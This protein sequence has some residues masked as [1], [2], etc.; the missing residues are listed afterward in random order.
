MLRSELI[1]S[2]WKSW[3][4]VQLRIPNRDG[5]IRLEELVFWPTLDTQPRCCTPVGRVCVLSYFGFPTEMMYSGWKCWFVRLSYSRSGYFGSWICLVLL[6]Y[7]DR[8]MY[9]GAMK[10]YRDVLLKTE[11]IT[12][13]HTL[14][15]IW[16][17][18]DKKFSTKVW[19]EPGY[20]K[21]VWSKNTKTRKKKTKLGW[22]DWWTPPHQHQGWL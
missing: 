5:V 3:C 11:L 20:I 13:V 10:L 15:K 9:S 8:A 18:I 12:T 14:A 16:I 4:F 17:F 6:K 7:L 1:C 21:R 2:G 22:R 19:T